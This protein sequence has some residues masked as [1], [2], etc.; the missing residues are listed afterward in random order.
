[1]T[2]ATTAQHAVDALAAQPGR[3]RHV[4]GRGGV[5]RRAARIGRRRHRSAATRRP[6]CSA[7]PSPRCR[8][9]SPSR[10]KKA[11]ARRDRRH[12]G[13]AVGSHAAALAQA[14]SSASRS[15]RRVGLSAY[16]ADGYP[17]RDHPQPLR[18]ARAQ[19][20]DASTLHR[21]AANDRA[22]RPRRVGRSDASPPSAARTSPTSP[23]RSTATPS[24]CAP[25]I[26]PRRTRWPRHSEL[27]T[28][29][30]EYEPP[31]PID[32]GGTP[33]RRS[34]CSVTSGEGVAAMLAASRRYR[35]PAPRDA[36]ADE[37]GGAA[38]RQRGL[39]FE[40]RAR[41][42]GVAD[43]GEGV[44]PSCGPCGGPHR[45]T[46]P[47]TTAR[48]ARRGGRGRAT[49]MARLCCEKL[50]DCSPSSRRTRCS[51]RARARARRFLIMK[52]SIC[53]C[54]TGGSLNHRA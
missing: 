26:R 7:T 15:A 44:A 53:A 39:S 46:E 33:T 32:R 51:R 16:D 43:D 4:D 48:L 35:H 29:S 45:R 31:A 11:G 6:A 22:S 34:G 3:L 47:T 36:V 10:S 18:G 37:I 5:A 27:A 41:A 17:P 28:A 12:R 25:T 30:R 1:M 24:G 2:D 23:S 49:C 14:S 52:V 42:A 50:I 54:A 38:A 21:D 19:A 9:S 40:E 13:R 20:A 8:T